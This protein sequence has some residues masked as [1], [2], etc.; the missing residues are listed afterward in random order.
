MIFPFLG[1][2]VEK[3]VKF[4]IKQIHG[5]CKLDRHCTSQIIVE[6]NLSTGSIIAK[7]YYVHYGH[8]ASI[9]NV[10]LPKLT[11]ETVVE[12]LMIGVAPSR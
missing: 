12:K 4:K 5:S 2:I 11:K 9:Q 1:K 8:T 10:R 7:Y 3:E 6:N